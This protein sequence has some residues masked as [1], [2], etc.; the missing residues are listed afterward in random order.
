METI[1]ANF[2]KLLLSALFLIGIGLFIFLVYHVDTVD[3][4]VLQ[5]LE[6]IIGQILAALL[7]LSVGRALARTN[8]TTPPPSA[9]GQKPPTP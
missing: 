7:T 8:D 6:Q 5:W 9:S 2:D 4:S 1:K 3:A